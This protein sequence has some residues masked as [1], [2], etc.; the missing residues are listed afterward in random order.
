[1]RVP[2]TAP[3][4]ASAAAHSSARDCT[5]PNVKLRSSKSSATR[6]RSLVARRRSTSVS[7]RIGVLLLLVDLRSGDAARRPRLHCISVILVDSGSGVPAVRPRLRCISVILDDSAPASRPSGHA[8]RMLVHRGDERRFGSR[9]VPL[10][11]VPPHLAFGY[12]PILLGAMAS[13]R[14]RS[15]SGIRRFPTASRPAAS[16]AS[17]A[18]HARSDCALTASRPRP[19]LGHASCGRRAGAAGAEDDGR[20][21]RRTGIASAS[22]RWAALAIPD[23]SEG[24]RGQGS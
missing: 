24:W 15:H 22:R 20:H 1:M 7:V 6:S 5:S 16:A 9:S 10:P 18:G 12:G 3:A 13:V 21:A 14:A 17:P 19:R 8:L 11:R 2:R 4:A 23:I